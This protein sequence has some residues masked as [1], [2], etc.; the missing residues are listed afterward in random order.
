MRSCDTL[1][2]Q[3]INPIKKYLIRRFQNE[4]LSLVRATK[5]ERVLDVGCGEGYLLSFL[6]RQIS[7]WHLEGFDINEELVKKAKDK[8]PAINL[9]VQDIYNCK[10]LDKS[11]DL[12]MNTEVLE[13]LEYPERALI[14][15]KRLTKR[16][17]ILSIPNDPLFSLS[18][19]LTGKDII[20]L[21]RSQG[22]INR[23]REKDFLDLIK[24]HFLI[25]KVIRPFP[26]LVLLCEIPPKSKNEIE[27]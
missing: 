16:W 11:F 27:H 7:D 26:W 22:H 18:N 8:L 14:E 10:F 20:T 6:D 19:F 21:G 23:W 3:T 2:Y 24:R 25:I 17:V 12:V 5:A 9:S 15:I 4:L 1:K 13:H